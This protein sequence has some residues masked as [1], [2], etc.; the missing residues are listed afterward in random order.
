[1]K[2]KIAIFACCAVVLAVTVAIYTSG[3]GRLDPVADPRGENATAQQRLGL[4]Y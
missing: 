3:P 2:I 4:A 1:M